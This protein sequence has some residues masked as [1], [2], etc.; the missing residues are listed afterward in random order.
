MGVAAAPQYKDQ[1]VAISDGGP[2]VLSGENTSISFVGTKKDGQHVGGFKTLTGTVDLS[3][4]GKTP[5]RI[6]VEID[7]DSLWSDNPQ[8]TNHLKNAD[9][10]ET[11][12]HP[13]ASFITTEISA[14]EGA[15]QTHTLEGEL[16]LHGVTNTV[17]VPATVVC[18]GKSISVKSKFKINRQEF[19][20]TFDP[21]RVDND[22]EITVNIGVTTE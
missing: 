17:S 14:A 2:V 3:D 22:V 1:P 6:E 11:Q 7:T 5:T 16:T 12:A 13:K 20:M 8:L 9:F 10:F 19:G 15:D 4:D 18:D 21:S